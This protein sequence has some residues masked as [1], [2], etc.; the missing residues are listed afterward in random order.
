[1]SLICCQLTSERL[2]GKQILDR[3]V[4]SMRQ[5]EALASVLF[6]VESKILFEGERMTLAANKFTNSFKKMLTQHGIMFND[7]ANQAVA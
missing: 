4:A 2:K 3:V 6:F 5:T 1:M 7:D